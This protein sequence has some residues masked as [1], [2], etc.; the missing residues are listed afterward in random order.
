MESEKTVM[1]QVEMRRLSGQGTCGEQGPDGGRK[2]CQSTVEEEKTVR[3][4]VEK[5]GC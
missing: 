1:V 4:L 2:E 3:V 5:K